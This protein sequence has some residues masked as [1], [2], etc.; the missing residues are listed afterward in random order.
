MRNKV[1]HGYFGVDIEVIWKT[2]QEDLPL[3]QATLTRI[4]EDLKK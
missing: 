4:F 3:L 1:I 2:V